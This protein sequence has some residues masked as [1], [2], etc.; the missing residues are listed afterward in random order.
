MS[1][2]T[3]GQSLLLCAGALIVLCGIIAAWPR[4]PRGLARPVRD[5]RSSLE[6][7]NRIRGQL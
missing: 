1:D 7:W 2:L 3:W 6:V 4:K 5:D